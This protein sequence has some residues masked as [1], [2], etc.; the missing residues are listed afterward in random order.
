MVTQ[1]VLHTVSNR[2]S[3][4]RIT[5]R[6]SNITRLGHAVVTDATVGNN[7]KGV[8]G[9][10]VLGGYDS[11]RGNVERGASIHMPNDKNNT[12]VVGVQSIIYTP[13]PNVEANSFS[14]TDETK[15]FLATIDSTLPYLWLPD[16]ICDHFVE[17]FGLVYDDDKE[18]YTVN[19][20]AH[21]NN[22]RLNATVSFRIGTGPTTSDPF[23][24]IDLPYDA[25]YSTIDSPLVDEATQYFPIKKSPNGMYVLGR[26]FL[27]ESYIIVDYE[28]ANFTVAPVSHSDNTDHKLVPIY[29]MTY[30]PPGSTPTPIPTGGN[31]GGLSPGAVAGIVVG[32]VIAFLLAGLGV[33]FWWKKRR[34]AKQ[35][36]YATKA[37]EIDTMVAGTE[38]KHRRISELDSE[39]PNSPK[40]SIAGL[41]G[42]DHKDGT[43][44]PPINEME[45]PPAELYS[46]PP[47]SS[48][49]S[50]DTSNVDYFVAGGKV[51]RRGATRESSG[52]NT[53]GT[54]GIPGHGPLA[55]LPGDDGRYQVGGIH[56]DPIP[57][58]KDS[59]AHSRGASDSSLHS[60][61]D[62]VLARPEG[63]RER[64]PEGSRERRP[65]ARAGAIAEVK[66]ESGQKEKKR[67]N[68]MEPNPPLERRASHTRGLSDTTVQSDTTVVSQPTPEE[69]EQW[70]MGG[71]EGT[72]RRPLSGENG[73]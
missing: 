22:K 69:L 35:K 73:T 13:D 67:E 23:T 71:E 49:H 61:I 16:K 2:F 21:N 60:K 32:V 52:N 31:G 37:E 29:N 44:F 45:S 17:R 38:V 62:D 27:Q 12:L 36:P 3:S 20:T 53:P 57:S 40:S 7:E 50:E 39:P 42:R 4:L 54:P 1:R 66:E 46:P 63:S 64:R 59:P 5:I 10:L 28:R 47:L 24:A 15:G 43:P 30:S 18:I 56:F 14:F 25:F 72:A 19:S 70:A 11:N 6:I 26:T 41:Y 8:T 9:N 55:E 68:E 34:Q 33:F 51:R 58:P 65:E 48:S